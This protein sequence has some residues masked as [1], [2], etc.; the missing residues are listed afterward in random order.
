MILQGH[1]AVRGGKVY[2]RHSAPMFSEPTMVHSFWEVNVDAS[3]VS[4]GQEVAYDGHRRTFRFS[5]RPY[6]DLVIA[7]QRPNEVAS[8]VESEAI[9]P[10]KTRLPTRWHNG[11]WQRQTARGWR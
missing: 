9:E 2:F 1:V 10:P 4:E 8:I 7:D 11:Q 3:L 5:R 6:E